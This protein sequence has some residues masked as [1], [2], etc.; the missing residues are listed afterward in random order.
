MDQMIE[1]PVCGHDSP[2]G[3]PRCP[4]CGADLSGVEAAPR[5]E[6]PRLATTPPPPPV[7]PSPPP[8]PHPA[9][10][11]QPATPPPPP[12]VSG[13]HADDTVVMPLGDLA[14]KPDE[15]ALFQHWKSGNT[16]PTPPPVERAERVGVL[17]LEFPW[18]P[19]EVTDRLAVGRDESS[20]IAPNLGPFSNISRFHADISV[21]GADVWVVDRRSTNGTF[22]N[23]RRLPGDEPVALSD[24]DRIRFAASLVAVVHIAREEK[25]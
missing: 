13:S 24:G 8:P 7:Q 21:D 3:K 18:G 22:L 12:P 5:Q 4:F 6:P 9:P 16:A 11:I 10:P 25:G 14:G 20:P 23:D 15:A 19:V 17:R 1:C 2:Q